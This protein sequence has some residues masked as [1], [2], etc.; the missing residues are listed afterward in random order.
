M[1]G[2]DIE[3]VAETHP[4]HVAKRHFSSLMP[5]ADYTMKELI[6]SLGIRGGQLTALT[7]I[8]TRLARLFLAND[9]TLAEVNPLAQLENGSLRR[10]RLLTSIWKRRRANAKGHPRPVRRRRGRDTPGAPADAFEIRRRAGRRGRS[11]WRRWAS[12]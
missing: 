10:P 2:I 6:A 5:L 8:A 4:E 9:L 11:A 12:G 3:E 7:N 1:G